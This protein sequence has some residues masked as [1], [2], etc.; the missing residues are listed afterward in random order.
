MGVY[1]RAKCELSSII[2]T[3]F[4]WGVEEGGSPPRTS[5]RAPKKHTQIRVNLFAFSQ[6]ERLDKSLFIRFDKICSEECDCI[7]LVSSAKW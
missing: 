5:K 2:I 3:T 4:R 1:V 6:F 7:M